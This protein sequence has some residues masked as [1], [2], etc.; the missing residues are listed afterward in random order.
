MLLAP[1]LKKI[2]FI[3]HGFFGKRIGKT[4]NELLD[5]KFGKTK[6]KETIRQNRK[7]VANYLEVSHDNLF[8]PIQI[9][10]NIVKFINNNKK[11]IECDAVITNT[12]GLLLGISTADCCPILMCDIQKKYIA[13]IHSG[14]KGTLAGIIQNTL[15]E[16]K[17][18]ECKNVVC[19]IGPCIQQCS[20][21][22]GQEIID[23]VPK[24]YLRKSF[25][26]LSGYIKNILSNS[27]IVIN[28]FN[29]SVDTF[30]NN[31]YFSHREQRLENGN[32]KW[33]ETKC[34]FSGIVYKGE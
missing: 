6:D 31:E 11:E 21:E 28:V 5:V 34:Q 4:T 29:F 23:F 26:D 15:F 18:L 10:S 12:K 20:F 3:N 22:V 7:K 14:W 19:A 32:N 27:E 2:K 33:I 1:N 24:Q 9:H 13:V 30:S 16:L 25:F 17:K 8:M